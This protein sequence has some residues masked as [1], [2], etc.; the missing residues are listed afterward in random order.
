MVRL[1]L[2]PNVDVYLKPTT[3]ILSNSEWVPALSLKVGDHITR[4][5]VVLP[6]QTLSWDDNFHAFMYARHYRGDDDLLYT[7]ARTIFNQPADTLVSHA[8]PP[9]PPSIRAFLLGLMF[10][11]DLDPASTRV[12][13]AGLGSLAYQAS[14]T[15]M[16]ST[17]IQF[18]PAPQ[19]NQHAGDTIRVPLGR[20]WPIYRL[21]RAQTLEKILIVERTRPL[22]A[23]YNPGPLTV[24]ETSP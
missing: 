20:L 9:Q 2:F 21:D 11:P 1:R 15:W 8:R 13:Q 22:A 23:R 6:P 4:D 17:L 18:G 3:E 19:P 12:S 14:D 16:S 24:R 10:S 7:A 5:P